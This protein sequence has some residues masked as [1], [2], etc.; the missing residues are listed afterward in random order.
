MLPSVAQ[1]SFY[2]CSNANIVQQ[3]SDFTLKMPE[4]SCFK[5]MINALKLTE[6]SPTFNLHYS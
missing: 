4:I 6:I 5:E 3:T 1:K 2:N